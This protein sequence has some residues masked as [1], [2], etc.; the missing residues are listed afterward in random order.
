MNNSTKQI[1]ARIKAYGNS[2]TS[3]N[4]ADRSGYVPN[5]ASFARR[6]CS[7][8]C[9]CAKKFRDAEHL[10]FWF[11]KCRSKDSSSAASLGR[12]G[13]AIARNPYPCEA[14]DAETLITRLYLSGRLGAEQLQALK[15]FGDRGRAPNQHVWAEN[16]KAALWADAMRVIGSAA[17]ERG[18]LE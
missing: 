13:R 17:A 14:I 11:L 4:S 3:G 1:T 7:H 12:A 18:W 5:G 6:D 10:W 9:D 16:K 8:G 15:E 2:S